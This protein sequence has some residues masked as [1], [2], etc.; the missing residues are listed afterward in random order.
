VICGLILP[1]R[2]LGINLFPLL[3]VILYCSLLFFFIKL[4]I[5]QK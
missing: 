1:G 3:H 5:R 2:I 4:L